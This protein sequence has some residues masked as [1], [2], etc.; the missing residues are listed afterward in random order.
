MEK[1]IK[2]LKEGKDNSANQVQTVEKE[3]MDA[4]N[5]EAAMKNKA[6]NIEAEIK[7]RSR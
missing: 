7:L 1:E 6:G 5:K 3:I 2:A 4:K